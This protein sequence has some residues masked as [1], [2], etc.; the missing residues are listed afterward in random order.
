MTQED[1]AAESGVNR[2]SIAKMETGHR[3]PKL[4]TLFQLADALGIRASELVR[5]VEEEGA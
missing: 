4:P 3:L 5:L 2:V 1:L